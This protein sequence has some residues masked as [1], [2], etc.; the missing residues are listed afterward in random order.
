MQDHL[1]DWWIVFLGTRRLPN[2]FDHLGRETFLAPV[3]WKN[4]WPVSSYFCKFLCKPNDVQI[5][6]TNHSQIV[7]EGRPVTLNM[8]VHSSLIQ[9][10]ITGDLSFADNFDQAELDKSFNF[11]RNPYPDLYSLTERPG[12]LRIYS[13]HITL[14]Q[15]D[16]P[17]W[18]GRRQ[19]SFRANFRTLVDFMPRKRE[20]EAGLTL[21]ANDYVHAEVGITFTEEHGRSVF[22]RVWRSDLDDLDELNV[23]KKTE[24]VAYE[25]LA[26]DEPVELFIK[27]EPTS[28][29]FGYKNKTSGEETVLG[30]MSSKW[31][32]RTETRRLHFTGVYAAMYC[33]DNGHET[34]AKA[35][36]DYFNVQTEED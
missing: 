23:D 1:G 31:F 26:N 16:S 27:A 36:F 12:W 24:I 29:S 22:S 28:Y 15:L 13:T 33:T 2:T 20:Q 25:S 4:G 5:M 8:E 35:D 21:H 17:A 18:V 3:T 9:D 6:M 7:N 10:N 11:I 34:M 19:Q 30:T 32:K 14:G